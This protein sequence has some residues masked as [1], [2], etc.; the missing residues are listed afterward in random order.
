MMTEREW[1][2]LGLSFECTRCGACCTGAEGY[3]WVTEAEVERLA[4]YVAMDINS[5]G[6]RYLRVSHGR[7]SLVERPGGDCVFWDRSIGCQVYG[8]RP[9]Q[10]R[11]W[12]F[13]HSNLAD[14]GAWK[15]TGEQCPGCDQGKLYQLGEIR[16]QLGLSPDRPDWPGES[17]MI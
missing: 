10:C 16:T 11:S 6:R 15:R 1:Y 3:V 13:W 12:P 2:G 17:V 5:F 14:E 9:D 7:L 4:E 8:A